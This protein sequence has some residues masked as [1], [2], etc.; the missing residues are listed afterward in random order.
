MHFFRTTNKKIETV[1]VK[2]ITLFMHDKICKLLLKTFE[3]VDDLS[4]S[5]ENEK[6]RKIIKGKM[7]KSTER[8]SCII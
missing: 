6:K 1:A 3:I 7:N 8:G 2:E 4:I 5:L